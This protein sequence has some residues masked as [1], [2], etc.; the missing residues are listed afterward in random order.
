MGQF[1]LHY[2]GHTQGSLGSLVA[3][4]SLLSRVIEFQGQDTEILSIKD[5]VRSN[6]SE[7]S[8]AIHTY[9]SLRYKEW[10]MVP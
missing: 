7:E 4:L 2:K 9:G 6:T 3:T 8:W 10:V 5:R 1:G